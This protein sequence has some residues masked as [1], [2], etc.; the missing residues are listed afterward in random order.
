MG[1]H[2]HA[3]TGADIEPVQTTA[4]TSSSQI[5]PSS[6]EEVA[7]QER[8]F[9]TLKKFPSQQYMNEIY[10]QHPSDTPA[11][12]RDSMLQFV[13]RSY[14]MTRDNFND[15]KS[16][17]WAGGG[18]LAFRSGLIGDMFGVHAAYY[19]SQPLFAPDD[20]SGSKLL[21]PEQGRLACGQIYGRVQIHDQEFRGGRQLVDTPLINPQDNRMVPNTFEGT[22]VV[23]LPDKDRNYDYALGY[24]WNVKQRDANGFIS[25]SDALAS[26]NTLDRGATFGMV[27]Y[28]PFSGFSTILMDYYVEDF[29]NTGFA[30]AEYNFQRPKEVPNWIIA[31]NVIDQRSVGADLLTGSS[32]QTYQASAKVLM[33]YSGWSLFVSGSITGDGSKIFSPFGTKPTFTDMQQVSFDN[34]GEK[35][36]GGSVEY[37]FSA[38][39]LSGVSAGAWY[40]HG[41]DAINPATNL[42]IPDRN[43]LDVWLQYRPTEGPLKGFRL[44]TQY[45]NVWQQG[46]VRDTQP[47]FRFIVDYTVLFRPPIK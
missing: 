46:N 8:L 45:A 34:A 44:K 47:E 6:H 35:A 10:W 41:W 14:Y 2:S 27:K 21:N 1:R 31:A 3:I 39:G 37:D 20:E 17:A 22:T 4:V 32:F 28:R 43:E 38:V 36:V 26:G 16:Q 29:V 19:T 18:W 23:T 11:F 12:F 25:M 24:L 40:T 5:L 13:A 15:S 30:Q 42:D 33:K 7:D 9:W